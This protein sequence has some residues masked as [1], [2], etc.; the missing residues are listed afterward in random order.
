MISVKNI[1]EENVTFFNLMI[2][3]EEIY[4][5][6]IV[7]IPLWASND[8]V[9]TAIAESSIQVIVNSVEI[10]GISAQIDALKGNG[11]KLVDAT[12]YPFA[13]KVLSNGK[14]LFQRVHGISAVVSGAPDNLTFTIPYA[15]CKITEI[16]ILEGLVGDKVNFKVLD[17]TSGTYTGVPNYLLNQFGYDVNVAEKFYMRKSN[18][19][20][21]LY[22]GMQIRIEYDSVA[23]DLLPKT[24]YINLVLHEVKD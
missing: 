13:S 2:Q 19:D 21:D 16:E 5:I 24:V 4:E 22:Y 12:N 9:L 8:E 7:S 20:A 11:P 18:Y 17:S 15:A 6:P 23:T 10:S 3:P 14:K 1:S